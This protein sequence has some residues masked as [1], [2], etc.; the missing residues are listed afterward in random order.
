VGYGA[1]SVHPYLLWQSVRY[2]YDSDKSVKMREAGKLYDISLAA[3]LANTRKA[4]EAG[5]LKILSKIG[6]SL[7]SSY[8]GAQIFEAIGVGGE[9]I[10]MAFRGTPS[11]V[12]GLTPE[13]LAEEVAEWHAT[14]FTESAP[15]R[16]FNYGFVKYYQKKEHHENTPPMSKMLHKALE[17][18]ETDKAAGFDQYKLFQQSIASSPV[19]TIRDMLEMVSDRKPIPL[20]EVEPVEAI[21]KRFATGGMSLGALSREAHETLAIGVNRA[22]GRSNSGEGGED[23]ARWKPLSDVDEFGH[24]PTF[25]HLK[26]VQ[27]GDIAISKIKQVRCHAVPC[28]RIGMQTTCPRRFLIWARRPSP[29]SSPSPNF[30][31]PPFP[32]FASS[33]NSPPISTSRQREPRFLAQ[34]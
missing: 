17:T 33:Y 15:E 18:Y 16:L 5:V 3:S 20:E 6:I 8:H 14:A 9:L 12:G 34:W 11:R 10:K 21:M 22:G 30:P 4:L 13:D 29:A 31:P 25:P 28:G 27:N 24:S 2:L 19:S 32:C 1:S 23:E 26:G 7:L